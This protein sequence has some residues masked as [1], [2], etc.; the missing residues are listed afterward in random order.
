M[1]KNQPS[2]T[3]FSDRERDNE[4]IISLSG[5]E[6]KTRFPSLLV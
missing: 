1:K 3:D 6:K 2:L 4:E 5:K